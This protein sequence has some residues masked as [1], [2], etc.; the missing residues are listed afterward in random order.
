MAAGVSTRLSP[1]EGRRFGLTVGAAFLA[2]AGLAA[3]RGHSLA[4]LGFAG[5]GGAL[6]VTALWVPARLGPVYRFWMG[7]AAAISKITTPLV[8]GLV[9]FAVVTPIGVLLRLARRS[10]LVRPRANQSFWVAR[11]VEARQRTD[12]ERQ[13]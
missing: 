7:L 9:Y 8:L 1:S 11:E 2:L 12:M 13:F 10:Q 6:V 5:L 3:W 4:P